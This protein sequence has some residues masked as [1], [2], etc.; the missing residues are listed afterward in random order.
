MYAEAGGEGGLLKDCGGRAVSSTGWGGRPRTQNPDARKRKDPSP[1]TQTLVLTNRRDPSL[2]TQT[3]VLT[4]RR[5]PSPNT[6]VRPP[7]GGK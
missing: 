2:R 3:L 5:D 1:R 7:E 6:A 4:N